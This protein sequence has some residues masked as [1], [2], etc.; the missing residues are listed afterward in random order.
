LQPECLFSSRVGQ[1]L[2]DYSDFGDSEMP[3]SPLKDAWEAIYTFN[4][5]WG[6]ITHDVDFKTPAEII[7]LIAEAS[8]KGGNLMLNIGPDGKGN[9]PPICV[10]FLRETGKWLRL[11]GESIYKTTAGFIPAQPWGVTT[12]KP[13]KLY[14]HVF[15][16]PVG[17]K[18][19][20]PGFLPKLTGAMALADKMRLQFTR[21]GNDVWITL[22][23]LSGKG[24]PDRVI[25]LTYSGAEPAYNG[26][27]PITVSRDYSVNELPVARAAVNGN[28][29]IG[30]LTF[31]HYFGDWKHITCA[32]D[33]KTPGD[34]I[35]FKAR[36]INGGYYKLSLDY[37]CAAE[38]SNQDGI[39]AVNGQDYYF[40][41][42]N[43]VPQYNYGPMMVRKHAIAVVKLPVGVY[44]ITIRPAQEGKE[45]FKLKDVMLEPVE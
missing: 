22:P 11:N 34:S 37:A 4:D 41:T 38:S 20:V 32:A 43:T 12:S 19:L 44:P 45:L 7:R 1:G 8:S 40:Q 29:V 5:T 21:Q 3:P 30:K 35:A 27:L 14:L 17:N 36:I 18:V 16:P 13:G 24:S 23:A 39:V 25:E 42:L 2:G 28:A 33:M 6:Y 26:D 10:D 31:A 9:I 15:T